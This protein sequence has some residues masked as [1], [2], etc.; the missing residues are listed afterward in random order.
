MRSPFTVKAS[1]VLNLYFAGLCL[2]VIFL[3]AAHGVDP[4]RRITQY[5]HTVWR[6]QD[7]AFTGS[8]Q[9]ITQTSD[10]YV[11]IGTSNGLYRFD[12]V[13]FE[14]FRNEAGERLTSSIV[15]LLAAR[16][17][18]LW[19]TAR[20]VLE[21][22]HNGVLTHYP[23]PD[24]RR[25]NQVIQTSDG[26][27]WVTF[28]RRPLGPPLCRVD[29][30]RLR[31][32]G[33]ADGVQLLK[34]DQIAESADGTIWFSDSS[35]LEQWSSGKSKITAP[36]AL[37]PGDS[38]SGFSAI[39]AAPDGTMWVGMDQKG[40]GLG[41]QHVVHDKWSPLIAPG[42]DS[43]QL[44]V[45]AVM[46]DRE[47]SVWVGTEEDGIYRLHGTQVDRYN[48]GNGLSSNSVQSIYEDREGDIWI[49][50]SRGL[51]KFRDEAVATVST[52]EGLALDVADSVTSA[53]DGSIWAGAGSY[54]EHIQNGNVASFNHEN[55]LPGRHVTSLFGDHLNRLWLGLDDRL[56]V[57]SSGSF[58]AVN[59]RGG[60]PIGLAFDL[61]E[62]ATGTV[63]LLTPFDSALFHVSPELT[64]DAVPVPGARHPRTLTADRHGGLWVSFDNGE[65]A[66]WSDGKWG[67][68]LMVADKKGDT[69]YQMVITNDE[70]AFGRTDAGLVGWRDGKLRTFGAINGLPCQKVY[71]FA[72]DHQGALWAYAE[73]GLF[74][75]SDSQLKRWWQH[76]DARLE[77]TL[78]STLDGAEP[79][80]AV[81]RPRDAVARDGT[82]WFANGSVLQQINPLKLYSNPLRPPVYVEAITADN[83]RY[84]IQANLKLP[85]LSRDIEID[86]T[87]LS[88]RIPE[89]V[90]F[91]YR[92][93]GWDKDWQSA[94][95]RRQAFYTNLRPGSYRF[96]VIACNDDGL[97]DERGAS[98]D[99]TIAPRYYQTAWFQI[100]CWLSVIFLAW[101]IYLLRLQQATARIQERLGARLE[102][103]ERIARE[104]H[105]TLLQGVQGLML[106]FQG[107]MKA[108]PADQ[109]TR[110]MMNDALDRADELMQQARQGVK[111]IRATGMEENDLPDMI[112]RCAEELQ[113][114]HAATLTLTFAGT[115][116]PLDVTVCTE[117]Y[118]IA[119]EAMTNAIQHSE[120]AKIEVELT[121]LAEHL[122]VSVRD[123]GVGIESQL[124][125]SGRANHWGMSG[126]RERAEKIG[127]R[128]RIS[129]QR[130]AGTEV[131]V[132]IPAR[133]AYAGTVSP[134]L[135]DKI[136][137]WRSRED[138][139]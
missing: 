55:G 41:L 91:R 132:T 108:L 78:F 75:I 93:D 116:Q 72:L 29:G 52:A 117:I 124:L 50:T 122:R 103:R 8:P 14:P 63:W 81:F 21:R 85:A 36:P 136:N 9:A 139:H 15:S 89:R 6:L 100:L 73:C 104:L 20:N 113:Q 69:V 19:F 27:I 33:T 70:M 37:R 64:L 60:A 138:S 59:K 18:S 2:F 96:H 53:Q 87:A 88:F 109:P 28:T 62:D 39:S 76:P 115:P 92:L 35:K 45:S 56:F 82:I 101:S 121:Y 46:Q 26:A 24:Q 51:D 22:L 86:Y 111:D 17:G 102:E 11:W 119:R 74:S 90:R 12:G 123:N 49:A 10:G 40:I 125:N 94:S 42:F 128:F 5:G 43:S 135:W 67:S 32:Y 65:V 13:R 120:A 25:A 107:I 84:P 44:R 34:A 99:F 54:L 114:Y 61:T 47:G 31:C 1:S 112:K 106:R 79:A 83:K 134:S 58:R 97:W 16:D 105:D 3:P 95:T 71:S 118:R 23:Q 129:S 110:K 30:L 98:F 77:V 57:Y 130:G 7:G 4:G 131:E 127:A 48:A 80:A 68:P 133:L 66:Y 38:I 137:R 126:M